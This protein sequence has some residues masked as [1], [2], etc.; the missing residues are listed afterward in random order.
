MA[1]SGFIDRT[2]SGRWTIWHLTADYATPSRPPLMLDLPAPTGAHHTVSSRREQVVALLRAGPRATS[3]LAA[4]LRLSPQAVLR[5]LRIL[6][7]AGIVR[8]TATSRRSPT[9]TWTLVGAAVET[10][11]AEGSR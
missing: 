8:P 11:P 9:N 5:H 3:D 6:E 2:S 7:A 4:T 10:S 1:A